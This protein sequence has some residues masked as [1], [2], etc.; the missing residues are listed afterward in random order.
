MAQPE[1][2]KQS[3]NIARTMGQ[4][5]QD[6]NERGCLDRHEFYP[7]DVDLENTLR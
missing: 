6:L 3:E 5:A 4:L 1:R 7:N 2:G